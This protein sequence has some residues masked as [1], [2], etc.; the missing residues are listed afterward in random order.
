MILCRKKKPAPDI[1]DWVLQKLDL[2]ASECIALEDSENGLHASLAAGVKT[3]VTTND[4]T[5]LQDFTGAAAVFDDLSNLEHF[6][7]SAEITLS[8]RPVT[9]NL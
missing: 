5:R 8:R 3:F 7:H 4:Y 1:Y 9:V 6:Y 2:N